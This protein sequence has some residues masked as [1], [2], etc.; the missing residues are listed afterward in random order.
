MNPFRMRRTGVSGC[1]EH[2]EAPIA[3]VGV[4]PCVSF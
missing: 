1:L 2:E 4:M 3:T